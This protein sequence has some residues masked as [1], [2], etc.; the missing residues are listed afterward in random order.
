[1]KRLAETYVND[2]III[3][4]EARLSFAH[5]HWHRTVRKAQEAVELAL[6][7][8]LR[9]AGIE[10]SKIHKIGD[11]LKN[12][13]LLTVLTSEE[14]QQFAS[15][16]DNLVLQR[17]LAFYGSEDTGTG[18]PEL[19]DRE[20]AQKAQDECRL[21]VLRVAGIVFPKKNIVTNST[22]ASIEITK[23]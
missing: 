1:M 16:S 13:K 8:L 9:W 15:I 17:G 10:Y 6:K 20:A 14:L 18:A 22:D 23:K 19:F 3:L 4:D 12:P 2:A 11:A 7:G 21:V 5:G